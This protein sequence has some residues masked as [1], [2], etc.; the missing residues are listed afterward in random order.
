[1]DSDT[2]SSDDDSLDVLPP[3]NKPTQPRLS[4]SGSSSKDPVQLDDDDDS[5]SSESSSLS[6][7]NDMSK[8]SKTTL[9]TFSGFDSDTS[10]DDSLVQMQ[11]V[12]AKKTRPASTKNLLATKKQ[13]PTTK[14][15]KKPKEIAVHPVDAPP[16]PKQLKKQAE[17]EAAKLQRQLQKQQQKQQERHA[18]QVHKRTIQQAT[19]KLA[20]TEIAILVEPS[21]LDSLQPPDDNNNNN[22]EA[23]PYLVVP[24]PSGLNGQAVQ[25]IRNDAIHGGAEAAVTSLQ[26]PGANHFEHLSVLALVV[27]ASFLDLLICGD[28][29]QD[30]YPKLQQWMESTLLGWKA[31]WNEMK[32]PRLILF[33]DRVQE[34][35]EQSWARK[36]THPR[37]ANLVSTEQLHDALTW[38]LIEFRVEAIHLHQNGTSLYKHLAK[39]TRMLCEMPYTTGISEISC[40]KKLKVTGD[41]SADSRARDCWLRQL[42]QLPGVSQR[43][44]LA[45]TQHYPTMLS[46][47]EQYQRTDL[48]EDEKKLLVSDCCGNGRKP[49]LS[50]QLYTLLTTDDPDLLI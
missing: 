30:N 32:F 29:Y 28:Q 42:Q 20:N 48:T 50:H 1:M 21:L 18:K 9:S 4:F 5:S 46:L 2:S 22:N 11:Q 10:D 27:D 33:L 7:T 31:S 19:G 25:W 34:T 24:F 40:V 8:P 35:L 44:A 49:K 39:M 14:A 47:F 16:N 41:N 6:L 43:V 3:T 17:R 12:L 13:P 15:S 36:Q 38:L 26:S 45:L 37:P 23:L